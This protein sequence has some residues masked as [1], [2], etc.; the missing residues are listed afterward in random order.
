MCTVQAHTVLHVDTWN[1]I[2]IPR[3][4]YLP[5]FLPQ[6]CRFFEP[7]LKDSARSQPQNAW[8]EFENVP[9]KWYVR[10]DFPLRAPYSYS[11]YSG[12]GQWEYY[13]ISS[14]AAIP[15]R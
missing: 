5:I 9:L 2:C 3:V 13:L 11:G 15:L 8:F 4:A 1:Q 7:H 14:P 12:T 6:I 10:M